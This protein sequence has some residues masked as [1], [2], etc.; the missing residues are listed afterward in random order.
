M[1]AWLPAW[2]VLFCGEQRVQ[3]RLWAS[4]LWQGPQVTG[5]AVLLGALLSLV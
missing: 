3:D 1:R 4:M 5:V 2:S